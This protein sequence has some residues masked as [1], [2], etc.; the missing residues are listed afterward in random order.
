MTSTGFGFRSFF[1]VWLIVVALMLALAA[2]G[3][4]G[5]GQIV[6]VGEATELVLDGDGWALDKGTG[7]NAGL[8]AVR[9]AGG[10]GASRFVVRGLKTGQVELVFRSGPKTFRASIDVL[11]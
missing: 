11:N 7:R 2:P 6:H 4:A 10:S 9:K 1:V 8:V 3:R 5:D